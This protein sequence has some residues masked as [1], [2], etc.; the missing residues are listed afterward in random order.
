MKK[1]SFKFHNEDVENFTIYCD[2]PE[3]Y[4]GWLIN[5]DG[6]YTLNDAEECLCNP[7]KSVEEQASRELALINEIISDPYTPWEECDE[8]D[9]EYIADTLHAWGIF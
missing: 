4:G 2:I 8:E 7:D 6:G 3:V 5:M 1:Y 9:R